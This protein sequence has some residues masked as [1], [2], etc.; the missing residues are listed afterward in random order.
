MAHH[1]LFDCQG[2]AEQLTTMKRKRIIVSVTNDLSTDQRVKKV[3]EILHQLDY[4]VVLVGRALPDSL[5]IQRPYTC[6]RFQ[7]PFHSGALFYISFQIRL[8]FFLMFSKADVLLSNDLDTLLPNFL[9]SKIKGI[10][11]VYDTHEYFCGVPELQHRPFVRSIWRGVEAW[12]FPK[13]RWVFTVNPSIAQLYYQDYGVIPRVFRNIGP[14]LQPRKWKTRAE[15]GL[16]E[17]AFIFINQGT[18]INID[19]GME[20]AVD[21]I[22]QIPN[23]CLLLVGSGDAIPNLKRVVAARALQD[24]V[25]FVNKMPYE[26]LLHFSQAANCGLSLD[27]PSNINY[28]FSLPN[29]IFD[30]IQCQKPII[31]SDLKEVAAIVRDYKVGLIAADHQTATLQD[32]MQQMMVLQPKGTFD[33]ALQKAA[34]TLHWEAESAELLKFYRDLKV[35]KP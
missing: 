18:G 27:K 35:G 19:R 30:Y 31:A 15:L 22:A 24:K 33:G 32:V 11:L 14:R 12:I 17:S 16:P 26:E 28:Q 8:F 29:K 10:S 23:A 25:L 2:L 4:E 3:A 20:E 9:A 7:L 5:P 34:E 6:R 1:P 21:A 13:L